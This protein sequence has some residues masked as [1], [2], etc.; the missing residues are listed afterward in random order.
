MSI[1]FFRTKP[2]FLALLYSILYF[3]LNHKYKFCPILTKRSVYRPFFIVLN[4]YI[5]T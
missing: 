1:K 4:K 3:L 5:G 2:D